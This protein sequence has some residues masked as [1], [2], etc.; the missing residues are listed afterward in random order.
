M[1][2]DEAY[3]PVEWVYRHGTEL[4]VFIVLVAAV[5]VA[6]LGL[7]AGIDDKRKPPY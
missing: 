5:F 6:L 2:P 4:L 1:S 3:Q 7:A